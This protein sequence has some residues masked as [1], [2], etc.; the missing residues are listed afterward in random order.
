MPDIM[1]CLWFDTQGREAAEFYVSVFENS[2]VGTVMRYDEASA[3]ASGQPEGS[4]LTVEFELDGH[5]FMALNG[6]PHFDFTPAVSF[7][8]S[9]DSADEIDELFETLSE[10]GAV[11]MPLQEYPFSERYG[12]LSDRY[13]VSWQL[14]LAPSRKKIT[15]SLMFVGEQH[16]KAEEAMRLYTSVFENSGVGTIE[17]YGP[18]DPDPAEGTVKYAEFSLDGQ[19]FRAMES[20]LDH[21]FGFTE[22]ISLHVSCGDQDEVDHFWQA[23]TEDGEEG[24]CG[25]LKDEFGVSWQIVPTVLNEMLQDDDAERAGRVMR[26]MLEMK[27]ID[28]PRLEEAYEGP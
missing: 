28:I 11:L 16:G 14:N 7:F 4:V 5:D 15:P 25:W 21:D 18:D 1:P 23:F 13:G 27:K 6:G 24:R 10:G 26:A 9:C 17:R 3:E 12:W 19:Q 8:V 20:S 2:G 22:A